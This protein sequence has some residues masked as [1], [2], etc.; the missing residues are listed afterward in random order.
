MIFISRITAVGAEGSDDS[1]L[2]GD[3]KCPEI[4]FNS[5]E[6]ESIQTLA[7]EAIVMSTKSPSRDGVSNVTF[8][9]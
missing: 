1:T 8:K 4:I 6:K 9:R 7:L 2:T 3:D 5:S